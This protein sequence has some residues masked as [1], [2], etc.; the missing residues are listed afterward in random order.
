[1]CLHGD[2]SQDLV[3]LETP[4]HPRQQIQCLPHDCYHGE[5]NNT[6]V[7]PW[8]FKIIKGFLEAGV[9]KSSRRLVKL[10]FSVCVT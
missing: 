4:C 1:M 8:R 3:G 5:K 2:D 6:K 10:L 9:N 7:S